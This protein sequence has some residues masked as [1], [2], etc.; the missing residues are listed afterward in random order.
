MVKIN[1][2]EFKPIIVRDS[3]NRRALQYKNK[4]I[5]NLKTFDLTE[6]DVDIHL[7]RIA[8]RKAEASAS[9]YMYDEHLFYSYNRS[10]KY[11]ENLAMV[12]QVIE[13]FLNLLNEKKMTKEEF[14]KMF[15]EDD[16]ILE[17]RKEARDVLGVEEDSTDFET[18]HKNYK[19]LSKKHHPDMP[20]GDTERFKA[21]NKAHK[22][23][24]KE[25]N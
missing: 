23:M 14:L 8:M 2:H 10:G 18:M 20:T 5:N 13:Y 24:R 7:E 22:L 4:I 21:L 17:Q 3:Y 15:V 6:D 25:L 9:W 19:N 11:V 16:D 1:G 12:A